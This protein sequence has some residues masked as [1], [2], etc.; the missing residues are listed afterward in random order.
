MGPLLGDGRRCCWTRR[1][2]VRRV[3]WAPYGRNRGARVG[4]SG[5]AATVGSVLLTLA[6]LP[7]EGPPREVF[8]FLHGILG[9]GANWRGFAKRLL[10][11]RQGIEGWLVDLRMHGRSQGFPAPH[12]LAACAED[13]AALVRERGG[14]VTRVLGHSF[15]GKVALAYA[16]AHPEG[17]E[18]VFVV[19]SNPG[20]PSVA[21][22][23]DTTERVMALLRTAPKAFATR[24]AFTAHFVGQGLEPGVTAWLA[25]NLSSQP[26]GRSADGGLDGLSGARAGGLRDTA[27]L[28]S[29]PADTGDTFSFKLDLA[30]IQA[31]LDDYMARDLFPFLEAPPPAFQ[32][33][34]V[35]VK[36]E[37]SPTIDASA[38]A[39]LSAAE[40]RAEARAEGGG[41]P[42]PRV[43]L[44]RV[45]DAGHW[46]HV[47]APDA[48]A[49]VLARYF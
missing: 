11:G 18:R 41:A 31:M 44:E 21:R 32:G 9:S 37:R 2:R 10:A 47:D 6:T 12:T 24:A 26:A 15:G 46:V 13:L 7:S 20:I 33:T 3:R 1:P 45:P 27:N 43:V 36:G 23:S 38:Q 39:R 40:A 25:M 5:I 34:V 48:L 22:A 19:D 49:A 35:V 29:Q 4:R 28:S 30:A 17:L 8:V 42:G 14:H 16:A